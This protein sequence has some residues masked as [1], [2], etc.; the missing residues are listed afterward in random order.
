MNLKE[1][2][3]V[4]TV[5]SIDDYRFELPGVRYKDFSAFPLILTQEVH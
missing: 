5:D 1:F 2:A 3:V 4:H